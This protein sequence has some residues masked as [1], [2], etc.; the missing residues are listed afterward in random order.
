MPVTINVGFSE[1]LGQPEFGS[2]GASCHI[3]CQLDAPILA[4]PDAFR[5]KTR[6]LYAACSTAAKEELA[7][8][9][10]SAGAS[11]K[12]GSKSPNGTGRPPANGSAT[13]HRASKRQLDFLEQLARQTP[14]VGVRRLESMAQRICQKP[15]AE[16]SSFDA[17]SLI[18]TL[19]AIKDERLDVEAALSGEKR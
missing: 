2:I 10:A 15:V 8:H 5:A 7:R 17:S 18:D 14:Q 3:E 16:L 9:R 4:S 19:K 13:N 6:E 12:N 1:K 11:P